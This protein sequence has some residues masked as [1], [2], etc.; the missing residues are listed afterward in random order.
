MAKNDN[1]SV[2]N[3]H[4]EFKLLKVQLPYGPHSY[5][6]VGWLVGRSANGWLVGLSEHLFLNEI[7]K[8]WRKYELS[9]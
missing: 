4:V 7:V 3:G 1:L 2:E 5:T 8:F 9:I 6:S